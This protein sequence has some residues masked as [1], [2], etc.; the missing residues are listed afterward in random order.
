M[1]SRPRRSSAPS[2][3]CFEASGSMRERDREGETRRINPAPWARRASYARRHIRHPL[4][5]RHD[6]GAER[7]RSRPRRH[8]PARPRVRTPAGSPAGP[9]LLQ[10]G[11]FFH[12]SAF[13]HALLTNRRLDALHQ[14]ANLKTRGG[15]SLSTTCR[16]RMPSTGWRRRGCG[17]C[18][19]RARSQA[20]VENRFDRA[21]S[22]SASLLTE[23]NDR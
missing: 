22:A 10:R 12:A 9:A 18:W 23:T 5:F 6:R 15:S 21:S 17:R 20:T 7:R 13:M 2:G 8:D 16:A 3:R 1:R 14:L 4:H 11:T 19:R